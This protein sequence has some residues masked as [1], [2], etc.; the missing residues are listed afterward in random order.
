[1]RMASV[2]RWT[3]PT[4]PAGLLAASGDGRRI[5]TATQEGIA[6][7]GA[8][9]EQE[10]IVSVDREPTAP[11]SLSAAGD[12][13]GVVS[14]DGVTVYG[15][16]GGWHSILHMPEMCATCSAACGVAVARPGSI[17][18]VGPRG[19]ERSLSVDVPAVENCLLV[20]LGESVVA[21]SVVETI[22]DVV[23]M[24]VDLETEQPDRKPLAGSLIVG[25]TADGS[26]L[27]T[28]AVEGDA[29]DLLVRATG[30]HISVA[31][32][33]GTRSPLLEDEG[34]GDYPPA[35]IGEEM[36]LWRSSAGRLGWFDLRARA[37]GGWLER[38]GSELVST[39]D[40]S[41]CDFDNVH[42]VARVGEQRLILLYTDGTLEMFAPS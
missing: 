42:H 29:C 4:S 35:R 18:R 20:A 40:S 3:T 11:L 31:G 2:A 26:V 1:M 17:A 14:A 8:E 36:L 32:L 5:V 16:G 41:R 27:A 19:I 23:A 37:F 28:V 10:G 25:G 34:F 30:E 12:L 9:L 24:V 33:A 7:L 39:D 21:L 38:A 6:V 13:I 15:E 22:T